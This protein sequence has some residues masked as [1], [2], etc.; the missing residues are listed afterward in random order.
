[1][2]EGVDSPVYYGTITFD[3]PI[4]QGE[5]RNL[6]YTGKDIIDNKIILP[7]DSFNHDSNDLNE[8][9]SCILSIDGEIWTRV[10]H[11]YD[12]IS[13]LTENRYSDNVYQ[14]LYDKFKRYVIE[15]SPMRNVP[16]ELDE[17]NIQLIRSIR[18]WWKRW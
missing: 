9:S 18:S 8:N 14:L 16:G 3:V 6:S 7:F 1:M 13:G 2:Q 10:P 11:F 5:I 4:V 17:I 12:R 15:F